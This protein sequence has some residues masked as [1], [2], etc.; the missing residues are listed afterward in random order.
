[1]C[2]ESAA[3]LKQ[4]GVSGLKAFNDICRCN[5]VLQALQGLLPLLF[6]LDSR[7]G[8]GYSRKIDCEQD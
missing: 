1:M 8:A 7:G 5:G 2:N 6:W 3:R 4:N